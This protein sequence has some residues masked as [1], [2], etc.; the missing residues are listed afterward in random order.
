MS[1]FTINFFIFILL[2]LIGYYTCPK[3][4]Q[5]L[6]LLYLSYLYYIKGGIKTVGYILF[7]TIS[8]WYS[9]LILENL[10]KN[11]KSDLVLLK[12]ALTK[13]SKKQ[14]KKQT[15]RRKQIIFW[16]TLLLNFGVLSYLK[17]FDFVVQNISNVVLY[18]NKNFTAPQA[19]NLLL[20][21]GI[22]FY[23]FQSIGYLIDVY[24][25]K[26]SAE[27][28]LF[29]L[30]LFVS[31]FPQIVQGPIGRFDHLAKQLFEEKH[32]EYQNLEHGA[33]LMLWGFFKKMLIADRFAIIVNE[34]FNNHS[35]YNG[36][37]IVVGVL[38]YSIQQYADFS[39]GIDIVTGVAQ[40][41]GI[42]LAENFRR[43]YF[44]H[45]LSEFWRRWHISL[46]AWMRDYVFYPLSLT[47]GMAKIGRFSKK[48]FGNAIG[49]AIPI[50]F[51]NIVVFLLVGIWHGAN[52]HFI[53]WGFYNGM[54]IAISALLEP[55]Y[56]KGIAKFHINVTS[57]TWKTFQ[58][59]RTFF[60]VNIGWYFDRGNNLLDSLTML[61][62]TFINF[63][64]S[65]LNP[66]ML[67]NLGLSRYDWIIAG[68]ATLLL[69]LISILQEKGLQI[70]NTLIQTNL[71]LKWGIYILL[72]FSVI[73]FQVSVGDL[74]GGFMYA[75]F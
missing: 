69:L 22:S 36:S 60:I 14:L 66:G 51:A 21:L 62:T 49:R 11:L 52:W 54:V 7:T 15:K 10:E 20:P 27:T 70:R 35:Q 74:I 43:P 30:A 48:Y 17:Y 8:I 61:K 33:I 44:S 68:I 41:F 38:A 55:L 46:G 16:L 50:C 26:Y 64:V 1:F 18:F 67:L 53:M 13:D 39:G 3:K 73:A 24:R 5:W 29:K 63:S 45:S 12:D 32:F 57:K 42:Q 59:F 72:F 34:V 9:S 65:D 2:G 31:F 23:T 40:M 56:E 58:I 4:W 75:H 25:G 37:I 47:K 19:L 28:N 6:W 71:V